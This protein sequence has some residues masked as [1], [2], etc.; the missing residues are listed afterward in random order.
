MIDNPSQVEQQRLEHILDNSTTYNHFHGSSIATGV[1]SG[2][3]VTSA[4]SGPRLWSS[5][6]FKYTPFYDVHLCEASG[7]VTVVRVSSR[8]RGNQSGPQGLLLQPPPVSDVASVEDGGAYRGRG[9]TARRTVRDCA[10]ANTLNTFVTLTY[11][12]DPAPG[13][14]YSEFTNYQRRLLRK[15]A[16]AKWIEVSQYGRRTRRLHHHVLFN[17]HLSLQDLRR[18]WD[19]GTVHIRRCDGAD[20]IRQTANYVSHDF[21]APR[22]ERPHL[23]RYRMSRSVERPQVT[24]LTLSEAELDRYLAAINISDVVWWRPSNPDSF[25]I[26]S[27]TWNPLTA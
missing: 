15:E 21:F 8:S 22:E 11:A 2:T 16:S 17:D 23:C 4:Q 7:R 20:D 25:V 13:E 26:K 6:G 24:K 12:S 1:V 27:G 9:H 18:Q 19:R 10:V 3:D 14:A 5:H